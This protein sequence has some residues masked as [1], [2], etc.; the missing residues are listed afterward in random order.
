M[1]II[2]AA[3][4]T[5]FSDAAGD[6]LAKLNLGAG[7]SVMIISVVDMA[8]PLAIDIYGGYLPAPDPQSSS[9]KPPESNLL[10]AMPMG[11]TLQAFEIAQVIAFL[12]SPE[13]DAITGQCIAVNGGGG[14]V[15]V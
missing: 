4:G 3:D 13:S 2:L 5:A 14:E 7:D 8:F 6:M 15:L 11:R 12:S 1:K 9:I 10:A